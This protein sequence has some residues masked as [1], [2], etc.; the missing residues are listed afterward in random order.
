MKMKRK[1]LNIDSER[2][3]ALAE[4]LRNIHMLP[5]PFIRKADSTGAMHREAEYW[6]YMIAICQSTRTL[7]GYI[8]GKWLRGGDYLLTAARRKMEADSNFFNTSR[9]ERITADE[10][11]AMLSDDGDPA[12]STID[13]VE[14]RVEQ[15][16]DCAR[17]L[18]REFGGDIMEVYGHSE[19]YI[20]RNDG[21][22]LLTLLKGFRAYSD[23]V[24]KKSHLLLLYLDAAGV[25]KVKD[26]EN[27][28][29]AVDYHLMRVALRSGIV[30]VEDEE[31]ADKLRHRRTV[32][33][34]EDFEVRQIVK[35]AYLSIILHSGHGAF[36]LDNMIWNL[37][38]SYC[39]SDR[40]PICKDRS[41]Q[42]DRLCS[43]VRV[44]DYKEKRRCPLEGVCLGR[45]D[46]RFREFAETNIDTEYY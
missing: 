40:D 8:D 21:K 24:E 4:R 44:T 25:W 12:N 15:L 1:R 17:V 32:T 13:R 46:D 39:F 34:E 26:P 3:R 7:K 36:Q 5:D 20:V 19:G 43:F 35:E 38:R 9:M 31:L 41:F 23:P 28:R 42:N 2:C 22:G 45:V 37:G 30:Q 16:R 33:I 10:L 14:E 6:F 29:V 18:R 11:R 27:L